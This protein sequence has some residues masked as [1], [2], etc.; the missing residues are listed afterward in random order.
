MKNIVCVLCVMSC[1]FCITAHAQPAPVQNKPFKTHSR[2]P[3]DTGPSVLG[4]YEGRFPCQAVRA[5]FKLPSNPACAK[6]KWCITLYH[7]SVTHAP[8]TYALRGMYYAPGPR[9]GKWTISKGTKAN[10]DAVVIQLWAEQAPGTPFELL[11][12]DD[13]VLFILDEK[14]NLR[15]GDSYLSYT[16][17]RITN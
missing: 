17:N 16:L 5:Q 13:N 8:T 14:R 15:V 3:H 2:T 9:T 7:D 12:G 6:V 11:K 10:P 4:S 1:L